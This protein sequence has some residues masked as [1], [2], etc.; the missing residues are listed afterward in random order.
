MD[1]SYLDAQLSIHALN[2]T[3]ASVLAKVTALTG[4]KIDLP[5]GAATERMPVVELG[6]GPV[7]RVLDELLRESSFDYVIQA[8]DTDPGNIRSVLLLPRDNG[9][10]TNEKVRTASDGRS[11]YSRAGAPVQP[12]E[13]PAPAENAVAEAA[14][15]QPPPAQ[16]D[17]PAPPAQAMERVPVQQPGTSAGAMSPPQSLDSQSISQQLQQMYQQR[18][19]MM[20]QERQTAGTANPAK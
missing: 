6:P 2:S 10:G 1:V 17:Q 3:L 12:E 8:S 20:Q 15:S 16:P 9:G 4:A 19:Q 5:A 13:A 11:P 14:N 7:R 18:V